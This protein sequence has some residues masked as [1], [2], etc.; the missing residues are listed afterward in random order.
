MN[1]YDRIAQVSVIREG[2]AIIINL[3]EKLVYTEVEFQPIIAKYSGIIKDI[4]VIT[5]TI[6][7]NVDV[8]IK[9]QA[10]T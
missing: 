9:K 1:N 4:K 2:T 5:G 3:S 8:N 10:F 6:N 7:V